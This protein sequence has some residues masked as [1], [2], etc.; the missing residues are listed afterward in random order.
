MGKKK[1]VMQ[2]NVIQCYH[3]IGKHMSCMSTSIRL[4][5][6]L[7][8]FPIKRLSKWIMSI[9]LLFHSNS[10]NYSSQSHIFD[11]QWLRIYFTCFTT[12]TVSLILKF[13]NF[14]TMNVLTLATSDL[15]F[16]SN[17]SYNCFEVWNIWQTS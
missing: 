3:P 12:E 16:F 9:W 8:F 14:P 5:L 2:S 1:I 11:E 6:P 7:L 15:Y 17:D 10:K 13:K 4:D